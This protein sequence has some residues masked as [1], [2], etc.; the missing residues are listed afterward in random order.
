[1]KEIYRN[2][3]GLHVSE[4]LRWGENRGADSG[5]LAALCVITFLRP[6]SMYFLVLGISCVSRKHTREGVVREGVVEKDG[7]TVLGEIRMPSGSSSSASEGDSNNDFE[8]S[9]EE[10]EA[11]ETVESK[12]GEE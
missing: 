2:W 4:K 3:I 10:E 12:E 11:A 7:V 8:E 5:V 1:L 6:A 9:D